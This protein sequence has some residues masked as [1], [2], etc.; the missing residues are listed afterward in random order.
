MCKLRKSKKR[1]SELEREIGNIS[2]KVLTSQLKELERDGFVKREI[3]TEEV[4]IK[5]EYSLTELGKSLSPV[6]QSMF[7]WG[8]KNKD[9]FTE[10]YNINI[11]EGLKFPK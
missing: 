9:S 10:Q 5:V 7:E 2:S 1:F 6:M 11:D 4:P 3:Y 8:M